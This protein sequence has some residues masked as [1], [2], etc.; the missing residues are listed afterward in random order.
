MI[1][2]QAGD[3][4]SLKSEQQNINHQSTKPKCCNP[5][6]YPSQNS[7]EF[8]DGVIIDSCF[9]SG[10]ICNGKRIDKYCVRFPIA[11]PFL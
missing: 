2:V 1:K 8:E 3:R 5:D 10:N 11:R 9:D 6:Y 7:F 4:Q